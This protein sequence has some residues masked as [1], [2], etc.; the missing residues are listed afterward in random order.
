MSPFTG[1][2][3]N[4]PSILKRRPLP[5]PLAAELPDVGVGD[6]PTVAA[7]VDE[8][9][10][11]AIDVKVGVNEPESLL[12]HAAAA[13]AVAMTPAMQAIKKLDFSIGLTRI[14]EDWS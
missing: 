2:P 5:E 9:T 6:A 4:V 13:M 8:R 12:L 14:E 11:L 3:L 10:G 1:E 7:V